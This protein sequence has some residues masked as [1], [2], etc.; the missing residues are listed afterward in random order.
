MMK[1]L[2]LLGFA[3]LAGVLLIFGI[4]WISDVELMEQPPEDTL[5]FGFTVNDENIRIFRFSPK[6]IDYMEIENAHQTYR[7]RM[8]DSK[9]QI[10]GFESV[11]LLTASAAGLFNSGETLRLDTK[12]REN[13]EDMA[14]FGLED[15]QAT[16][17]ILSHTGSVAKFHIGDMTPNH[18]Y[19]YMCVDGERTVYILD[20]LFAERYLKSVVDYCDLKIYKTFVPY[21]DFTALSITS[22][23]GEYS[24]RIATDAERESGVY[25][26]GIAMDKPFHWGADA[27]V[28][29]ALM[30]TMVGLSAD[31]AVALG[32]S[33]GDLAQYGLDAAS[34]TEVKL[35]VYADANPTMYNNQTNPFYDST[36]P[37][38]K[39]TDFS[40]T[41][42]LGKV[43]DNQVYVMFEDR[44][45][46]YTMPKDTFSWLEKRPYQFCNHMLFG[47]YIS[48]LSALEISTPEDTWTFTLKNADSND[49]EELIVHCGSVSV[50]GKQFRAFYANLMSIYPSGEATMP[51]GNPEAA[52]EIRYLR[53]NGTEEVVRF[54]KIDARNYAAETGG[55]VFLSVRVTEL[56]KVLNDIQ[57]L[58]KG[59]TILS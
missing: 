47:E 36:K 15:P 53:S 42:R 41:Y 30:K 50:N 56:D 23:A 20:T 49:K 33:D 29:E 7:V 18:D 39:Y 43:V 28:I 13:C 24:F 19:Y 54:Y 58:L 48:K 22:P 46:V 1:R 16:V 44:D 12:I 40:V 27:E 5:D 55:S 31:S 10:V 34:R 25:F 37:T 59:Q 32:V 52:L 45:V 4:L 35:S 8:V 3:L 6:N 21:E 57:K 2:I 9:V 38:G 26:G 14:E 11:P 17:T 51:E